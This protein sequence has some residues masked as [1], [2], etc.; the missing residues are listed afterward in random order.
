MS[1]KAE[2]QRTILDLIGR[3]PVASQ[4]ELKGLLAEAGHQVT[5]ATLSRDLRELGIVRAPTDDGPRYVK[6]DALVDEDRL[7]LQTLLPQMF[8]SVDGV[9]ELLVVR[10]RAGGA[11]A[12]AEAVDAEEWPEV[13]GTLAGENTI[14]I[15]CRSDS[16]RLQVARRIEGLAG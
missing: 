4:E 10:T 2:R 1:A 13:L 11:Q 6:P 7:S 9:R 8:A 14:L 15:I 5:Q 16:D 3:R 12:I